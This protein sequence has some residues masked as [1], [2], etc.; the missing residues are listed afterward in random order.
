[1]KTYLK[2]ALPILFVG[3]ML[4]LFNCTPDTVA[5]SP[6][7]ATQKLKLLNFDDV[8]GNTA[9][10]AQIER[11]LPGYAGR[12]LY[13]GAND[14]LQDFYIN[15]DHILE[16]EKDGFSMLTFSVYRSS[17]TDYDENLILVKKVDGTYTPYLVRYLL[18][19]QD[20]TAYQNGNPIA[21]LNEKVK[22]YGINELSSCGTLIITCFYEA[23]WSHVPIPTESIQGDLP[24]WDGPEYLVSYTLLGCIFEYFSCPDYNGPGGG[25]GGGGGGDTG[26]SDPGAGPIMGGGGG[27]NPQPVLTPLFLNSA[28]QRFINTLSEVQH[29]WLQS[30]PEMGIMLYDFF[31][32][33]SEMTYN[34]KKELA[35]AIID[36]AIS[37]PESAYTPAD[38]PGQSEGRPYRWWRDSEYIA[39]H[40]TINGLV[41]NVLEAILFKLFPAQALLHVGN[42]ATAVIKTNQLVA[43][44]ELVGPLGGGK[45]D[46]FRHAYWSALDTAE[47]GPGFTKLFTDAHELLSGGL[48]R[49]MDLFN[50]EKGRILAVLE[51][52]SFFTPEGEIVIAVLVLLTNGELVYI[53]NNVLTPTN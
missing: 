26:G 33:E 17:P 37:D 47:I 38:Y 1:M 13:R 35:H 30:H 21:D 52:F 24:D 31:T 46:A 19:E 12:P 11:F 16:V 51:E 15:T 8:K 5:V 32:V 18:S 48:P 22:V 40:F 23:S 14:T 50:N 20:K 4:L 34:E 42:A 36:L 27:G 25:G 10:A 2:K 44:G 49:K 43:D 41:P 9:A 29:D 6:H 39:T 53:Y 7:S 3:M 45:P 28:Y